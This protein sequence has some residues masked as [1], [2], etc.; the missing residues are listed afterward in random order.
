[1]DPAGGGYTLRRS[2]TDNNNFERLAPAGDRDTA[3]ASS[4]IQGEIAKG[5]K[6]R[7]VQDE[8]FGS[9]AP[10]AALTTSSI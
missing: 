5:S 7:W 10:S 4:R 6:R 8:R 3:H 9:W 1:M 2:E